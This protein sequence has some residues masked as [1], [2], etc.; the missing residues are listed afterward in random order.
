MLDASTTRANIVLTRVIT[1]VL[2]GVY[3]QYLS[4]LDFQN[5]S[6]TSV[7]SKRSGLQK[8]SSIFYFIIV[9]ISFLNSASVFCCSSSTH[10]TIKSH[11]KTISGEL[12]WFCESYDL[13]NNISFLLVISFLYN[14]PPESVFCNVEETSL[15]SW[16][17]V[18]KW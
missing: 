10:Y 2:V 9:F 1:Y 18:S 12:F 3:A 17:F 13:L 15:I 5:S 16:P 11:C 8:V 7:S 4:L 6:K 14:Q